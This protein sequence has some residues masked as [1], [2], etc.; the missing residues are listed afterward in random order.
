MSS[1]MDK[2]RSWRLAPR[3]KR[4]FFGLIAFGVMSVTAWAI[5]TDLGLVRRLHAPAAEHGDQ[6]TFLRLVQTGQ[7]EEAFDLAF[8]TGDELFETRFN[9][10]DGVGANVGDGQRFT[11]VPRADLQGPG[12][13]ANH[14]PARATGPNAESCNACHGIPSDDGAGAAS[15]NVHRDPLHSGNLGSFIQRNT[16]HTFS[17]G[18]VQRLAEEMTA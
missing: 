12:Q 8:E 9:A 4:G 2:L 10:L 18:S 13:W 16:P 1:F 6:L 15:S 17:P 7:G 11:R 14:F 5:V 3:S